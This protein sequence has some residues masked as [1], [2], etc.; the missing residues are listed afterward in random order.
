MRAGGCAEQRRHGTPRAAPSEIPER[1][2]E[3][4]DR[5][6]GRAARPCGVEQRLALGGVAVGDQ[7]RQR[8]EARLGGVERDAVVRSEGGDLAATA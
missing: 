3:T 7:L 8:G 6:G 2:V 4:G 5:T 1:E